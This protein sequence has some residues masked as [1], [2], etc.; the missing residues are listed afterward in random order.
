MRV[1]IVGCGYVGVALG[2]ELVREGHEVFGVRRSAEKL[3]QLIAAGIQPLALD[4]SDRAALA[5]LP[6]NVDVV[7]NSIASSRGDESDY[8]R[9]YLESNR[10][11]IDWLPS[12]LRAFVYTSSTGVYAQNDASIVT[13]ESPAEPDSPTSQVLIETEQLLLS[14]ARERSAPT[15]ILRCAGIYGPERGYWLRQ[16]LAGEARIEANGER[17]LNMI[18]RDDMVRAI[19]AAFEHGKP[20]EIYNVVD[21]EPVQQR[22]VFNW[23]AERLKKPMPPVSTGAASPGRRAATNKRV[24]NQKLRLALRCELKYPT[25]REGYAAELARLG[26]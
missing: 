5:P 25:F 8:R 4:V 18:H 9:T 21:D 23:L 16:F 3:D 20:G 6:T 10:N 17:W 1:L 11:L 19:I 12:S 7:V 24:S 15:M 26:Y 22:T 14:T 13:E 2:K